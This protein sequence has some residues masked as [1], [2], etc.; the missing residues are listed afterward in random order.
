MTHSNTTDNQLQPLKGE[1]GKSREQVGS[2]SGV[3]YLGDQMLGRPNKK[4]RNT[5]QPNHRK[6][7]S[8]A[9]RHNTNA[10]HHKIN[11][12]DTTPPPAGHHHHTTQTTPT[13]PTPHRHTHT[14]T[15]APHH[16]HQTRLAFWLDWLVGFGVGL[17]LGWLGTGLGVGWGCAGF[18]LGWTG[19]SWVGL[20]WAWF[21]LGVDWFGMFSISSTFPWCPLLSS[22]SVFLD[23]PVA[24]I[25]VL[26]QLSHFPRSHQM[27]WVSQFY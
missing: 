11:N 5:P 6:S 26:S 20:G 22:L 18:G 12:A 23:F 21:G 15:T 13:P 24:L 10:H 8:T 4:T 19:L 2:R 1:K 25:F 9:P 16:H 17:G 14:T 7:N 27:S 3:S